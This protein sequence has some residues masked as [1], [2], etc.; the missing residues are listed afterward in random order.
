MK[1]IFKLC[2]VFVFLVLSFLHE[3]KVVFFNGNNVRKGV[4]DEE[5]GARWLE[6]LAT[7][8]LEIYR[9]LS[10]RREFVI[11]LNGNI[12]KLLHS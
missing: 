5:A 11:I 12:Q 6:R 4:T 9:S 1:E 7:F 10:G 8:G 3:C 2:G